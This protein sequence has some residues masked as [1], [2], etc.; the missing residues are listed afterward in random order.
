M[1]STL[2]KVAWSVK[3]TIRHKVEKSSFIKK[4]LNVHMY[5]EVHRTF[6]VCLLSSTKMSYWPN[7]LAWSFFAKCPMM[8]ELQGVRDD[9]LNFFHWQHYQ[10]QGKN[11]SSNQYEDSFGISNVSNKNRVCSSGC[12]NWSN[13]TRNTMNSN[14]CLLDFVLWMQVASLR[15]YKSHASWSSFSKNF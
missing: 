12:T 14:N 13:F 4:K 1:M 3:S 7:V 8:P 6:N 10:Q 9:L 11:N 5:I 15:S 2:Q